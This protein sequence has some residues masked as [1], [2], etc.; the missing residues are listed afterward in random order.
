MST[1]TKEEKDK[2]LTVEGAVKNNLASEQIAAEKDM[3]ESIQTGYDEQYEALKKAQED[4]AAFTQKTLEEKKKQ[5]DEEYHNEAQDAY[6]DYTRETSKYGVG[7]EA[8]AAL[9]MSRTGYSE[10]SRVRMYAAYQE[11][12][13]NTKAALA[14]ARNDY[15]IAMARAEQQNNL[16]LAELAFT[17][18]Q[19]RTELLISQFN[20][21]LYEYEETPPEEPPLFV[22]TFVP[23]NKSPGSENAPFYVNGEETP[24][25]SRTIFNPKSTKYGPN[26][27]EGTEKTP[28]NDQTKTDLGIFQS[29]VDYANKMSK[30][31]QNYGI[32]QP[33]LEFG[34][35][36]LMETADYDV[37]ID[38]IK[39]MGLGNIPLETLETM[40][41]QGYVEEYIEGGKIKYRLTDLGK[42]SFELSV[43]PANLGNRAL[44]GEKSQ[45]HAEVK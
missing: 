19:R 34:A 44:R 43:K 41:K 26:M 3:Y 13:A 28:P 15:D 5:L 25:P 45:Y 17:A 23:A 8:M 27:D 36:K 20:A 35:N 14:S 38:S 4:N 16:A 1:T 42:K 10:S 7:A 30:E 37:D 21:G 11:R 39:R 18:F 2:Q 33:T 40:V 9:G 32:F 29:S 31:E 24:S 12:V 6:T 22:P